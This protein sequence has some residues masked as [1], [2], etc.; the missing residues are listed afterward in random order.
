MIKKNEVSEIKVFISYAREDKEIAEKVYYDLKEKGVSPW[1]DFV[2][3]VPG[4]RWKQKITDQ[5]RKSNHILLLCSSKSL[6]QRGY[7]L[8]ELN[9]A[10]DLLDQVPDLENFLIPVLLEDCEFSNERLSDIVWAELF[11]HYETGMDKIYRSIFG[12]RATNQKNE[13]YI[14]KRKSDIVNAV[15]RTTQHH[16]QGNF[17]VIPECAFA[18][19]ENRYRV[20]KFKIAASPVTKLE[21]REF[22]ES[23]GYF[24]D[25]LWSE[26]GA[27]NN[28]RK[29][30]YDKFMGEGKDGFELLNGIS[31]WEAKAYCKWEKRR[32]PTV[33]QLQLIMILSYLKEN[34]RL[35]AGIS[36]EMES[37]KLS[38]LL[39]NNGSSPQFDWGRNHWTNTP[40]FNNSFN[41]IGADQGG[42]LKSLKHPAAVTP[43]SRNNNILRCVL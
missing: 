5:M 20:E 38:A 23:G 2:N 42:I 17:I 40:C 33:R 10:L 29:R 34:G 13:H 3:L 36:L 32:T 37:E 9:I 4:N 28:E 26:T 30:N 41:M 12:G 27:T 39:N 16:H 43:K 24:N 8:K 18:I 25:Y 14:N 21:Y 7:F 15:M 11:P 22:A 35:P 31:Y 19:D 1:I 6:N